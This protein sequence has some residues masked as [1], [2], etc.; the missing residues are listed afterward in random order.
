[1]SRTTPDRI[2]M[3]KYDARY[4]DPVFNPVITTSIAAK[5]AKAPDLPQSF[6]KIWV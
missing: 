5:A 2:G 3:M 1:M 6:I 4:A